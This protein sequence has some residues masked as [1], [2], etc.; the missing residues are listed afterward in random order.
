MKTKNN[1]WRISSR[2]YFKGECDH[3][4]RLDMAVAAGVPEALTKT[5]PFKTDVGALLWVMQGNEYERAVFDRFQ[6]GLGNDFVELQNAKMNETLELLHQGTVAVAQGF[7]EH[8][9]DEYFWSGFPDLLLREDFTIED[10]Q[11]KKIAEPRNSQICC[12]GCQG[13]IRPR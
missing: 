2:D 13:N 3:C 5:E 12:L 4:T 10:G 8:E 6:A 7:L 1:K 11:I 9:T